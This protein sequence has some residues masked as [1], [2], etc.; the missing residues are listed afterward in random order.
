MVI[1][2]PAEPTNPPPNSQLPRS[3]P[4]PVCRRAEPASHARVK[5]FMRTR[6]PLALCLAGLLVAWSVGLRA[7][8]PQPDAGRGAP[9][10]G[11]PIPRTYR[12]END[13][14]VEM[15]EDRNRDGR[16]D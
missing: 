9:G 6:R 2:T 4:F 14:L 1:S 13:V 11:P 12:F 10:P 15:S 16:P 3:P 7:S 5:A 8:P